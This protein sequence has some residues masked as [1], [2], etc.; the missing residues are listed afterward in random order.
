MIK[1]IIFDIGGVVLEWPTRLE[2]DV[3]YRYIAERFGFNFEEVKEKIKALV[4]PLK[5]GEITEKECWSRFFN[6]YGKALPDDWKD[7]WQKIF[8]EKAKLNED[9]MKTVKA[10]KSNGYQLAV[11]TNTIPSH[12]AW[13]EKMKWYEPFDILVISCKDG[14]V[15]PEPAIF[16]L[17]LKKLGLKG[18]ECIFIDNV[19]KNIRGAERAGLHGILFENAEQMKK[20]LEKFGVKIE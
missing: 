18:H 9:V 7:L 3:I 17:A 14:V 12:N 19:E 2:V 10:L 4:Y 16:E 20:D 11:I 8:R 6:S 5:G 15:K 13:V 1:A